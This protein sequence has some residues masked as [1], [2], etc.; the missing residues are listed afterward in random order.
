MLSVCL[1]SLY[2]DERYQDLENLGSAIR[3]PLRHFR[4]QALDG[5]VRDESPGYAPITPSLPT[6]LL[7][8]IREQ[9]NASNARTNRQDN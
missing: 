1:D 7:A 5:R 8:P 6:S 2:Q 4:R 3:T 9:A